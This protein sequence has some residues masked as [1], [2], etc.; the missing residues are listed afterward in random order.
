MPD[1][2]L[3]R[4]EFNSW[5]QAAW[6]T[7]DTILETDWFHNR[8]NRLIDAELLAEGKDPGREKLAADKAARHAGTPNILHLDTPGRPVLSTEHNRHPDTMVDEFYNTLTEIDTEGNLRSVTDARGNKVMQYKYDMLGNQ[9]YSNSMDAGKRWLFLNITNH[10]V[11]TWDERD[12]EFRHSY[13]IL[14][15]PTQSIITGGDGAVPL[16]N[17]YD[18][19]IYGED[20]LLPGRTNEAQ[21]QERNIL[22]RPVKHYDSGGRIHTP[23]YDFKGLPTLTVRRLFRKYKETANWT[24]ANLAGDLENRDFTFLNETD[25]LGRLTLQVT[26]DNTVIIPEYNEAGLL[27]NQKVNLQGTSAEVHY[28]KDIDYNEK[29]QRTRIV[30]GNNVLTR[31]YYDSE[32]FR[33]IRLETKRHNGDPLQDWHYTYDPVGNITH[34]EDRNVPVTFY[35]NQKTTGLSTYDYDALYRLTEAKGRENDTT[36]S[37]GGADNWNDA[38][39]LQQMNPGDPMA[40]RNYT[41]KYQYDA[42]GNILQTSHQTTPVNSWTRNYV[43][44]AASN[45]LVNTTTGSHNYNYVHHPLHG[46]ITGMPHMEVMDWN[47]K[48]ELVKTVR[49]KLNNGGTPETTYYQYDGG[50]ERIRKITENMAGEGAV[51]SKKEERIYISGYELYIK[52]SNPHSGLERVSLSLMDQ[53]HRFVMIE[54]RNDVDDGT[55]AQLV[56]Y[57]HHNHLGSASLEL[58]GNANVISYEEYHPYGTTAYQA[59]N[60]EI[61]S[62]AKRYRYSGM[63]RDEETGLAYH[64]ARYYIPW[65]G[66]W[67]SADPVGTGGGINLYGYCHNN[68]VKLNDPGGTDPPGSEDPPL[69][70][71]PLFTDITPLGVA[72]DLQF[73]NMLSDDRS[74]SGRL[75]LS[76]G[77]RSSFILEAPGL[78]L[79][80]TGIADVSG[81]AAVDTTLGAGALQ[82]RGGGVLGELSGLNLVVAGE[83]AFRI[84]VPGSIGLSGLPGSLLSTLPQSEGQATLSGALSY[85]SFSL[86]DFRATA[87]LESGRFEGRLDA[88]SVGNI[89][90]LRLDATGSIGEQGQ[91]SVESARLRA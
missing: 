75:A 71:T 40:I 4:V 62:A 38:S 47:F 61:R 44:E 24:D 77:L 57:Q 31:F 5:K 56:R 15:R 58:D 55:A 52:H 8:T 53:G 6:D 18:R 88:T 34:I 46:F 9:V 32:T 89:A 64:S 51:P 82:L 79:R 83:G 45:R 68:P 41:Q 50:G 85:G 19:I 86:A 2:T 43:Y 10:P 30:Y 20:Q 74:V 49:Q 29:G 66:R 26:P 27:E 76:S 73:S 25:A 59:M 21:L 84:P 39:Y 3:S 7:N 16:N 28:I 48:E 91:V 81:T 90:D 11:R 78:G 14:H 12:F 70:L 17:I 13:D 1:A 87:S 80:T 22:G 69:R 37:S 72:G 35:N 23:E 60:A 65:L 67:L 63:E 33:L 36:P 54:T 42:V